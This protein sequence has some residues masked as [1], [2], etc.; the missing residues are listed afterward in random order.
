MFGTLVVIHQSTLNDICRGNHTSF[1]KDLSCYLSFQITSTQFVMVDYICLFID[2]Q[3]VGDFYGSMV[4]FIF[5]DAPLEYSNDR[6][7]EYSV[8]IFGINI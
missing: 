7:F 6:V 8:D 4:S 2:I 5:P 3:R 1:S